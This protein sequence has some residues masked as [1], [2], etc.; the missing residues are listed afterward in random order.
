LTSLFKEYLVYDET[1]EF[2]KRTYSTEE[3]KAKL[4]KLVQFHNAYFKVFPN[5]IMLKE[6]Y[7]MY[8]NIERKQRVIDD[9]QYRVMMNNYKKEGEKMQQNSLTHLFGESYMKNISFFR[10]KFQNE[11][12]SIG[13]VDPMQLYRHKQ[14]TERQVT[15]TK[16]CYNSIEM[17]LSKVNTSWMQIGRIDVEE[18]SNLSFW[19]SQIASSREISLKNSPINSE[20]KKEK[21]S[22]NDRKAKVFDVT[23]KYNVKTDENSP[24]LAV[25]SAEISDKLP[26][27]NLRSI[28]GISHTSKINVLENCKLNDSRR[29]KRSVL[30]ISLSLTS[31]TP[32]QKKSANWPPTNSPDDSLK[33]AKLLRQSMN[34]RFN[35]KNKKVL[36]KNM[37]N[38]NKYKK[39]KSW[40]S[41]SAL[42]CRLKGIA[43]K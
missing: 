7:Y 40:D 31:S 21:K 42:K 38:V 1:I 10:E 39:E 12:I 19:K 27:S 33:V 24:K 36:C 2:L 30:E 9:K 29:L 14:K 4:Q 13:G 5:F 23:D 25:N 15:P 28:V 43:S 11:Q 16:S 8:K 26:P 22:F 20:T 6:K 37:Q 3:A 17:V 34:S 35:K 41:N 32:N 18:N